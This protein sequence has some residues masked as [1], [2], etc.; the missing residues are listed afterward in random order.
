MRW[1]L[2]ILTSAHILLFPKA[3]GLSRVRIGRK[4]KKT[5]DTWKR[6]RRWDKNDK[7][8]MCAS[9]MCLATNILGPWSKSEQC[10][11]KSLHRWGNKWQ[12]RE[13]SGPQLQWD[14]PEESWGTPDL[15]TCVTGARKPHLSHWEGTPL[16]Q[17]FPLL[18]SCVFFL[19]ENSDPCRTCHTR[20][21]WAV[22]VL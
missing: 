14:N 20:I 12:Q 21:R 7:S 15:A 1:V 18:T 22:L 8:H 2:V 5:M 11:Q 3:I 13:S 17:P 9:H 19:L 6:T 4:V 10:Q 16:S